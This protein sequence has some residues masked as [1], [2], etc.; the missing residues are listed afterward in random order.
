MSGN[1]LRASVIGLILALFTPAIASA[2]NEATLDTVVVTASRAEESLREVSS[3]VTVISEKQIKNSTANNLGD[4]LKQQGFYVYDNLGGSQDLQIRGIQSEI[5]NPVASET[6]VLILINGRRTGI[7][8]L[9]PVGL[10]NIERIEII[11][12][13]AAV[14]YGSSALGGV[15]NLITKQGKEGEF[16]GAAETGVGSFNLYKNSLGFGGAANNFDFSAGITH[17]KRGDFESN[18]TTGITHDSFDGHTTINLD[19]GYTWFE[20]HRLGLNFNHDKLKDQ[21]TIVVPPLWWAEAESISAYENNNMAISYEGTSEDDQFNWSAVYSFGKDKQDNFLDQGGFTSTT[22]VYQDVNG[23]TGQVGYNG[24]MVSANI[25]LD[26]Y[27]FET[28]TDDYGNDKHDDLGIFLSTKLRLLDESLIFSAG[29]RYDR[30]TFTNREPDP[31][32]TGGNE[33]KFTPSVGVA[34]LP[35]DWLKIRTN[36]SEGFRIPSTRQKYGTGGQWFWLPNLD[37][38]PE[39]SKTFEFGSDVNYQALNASLTYFHTSFDNKIQWNGQFTPN[40]QAINIRKSTISGLEFSVSSDIGQMLDQSFELRP[41]LNLTYY[42]SRKNKDPDEFINVGGTMRDTLPYVPKY[43]LNYGMTF[44]HPGYDLMA[45]ING[46]YLGETLIQSTS[47][48]NQYYTYGTVSVD[49]SLEKGIY[50]FNDKNKLKLRVEVNNLLNNDNM[51]VL[52]RPGPERNFYVGL[53]YEYN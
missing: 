5:G 21:R 47:L 17:L 1:W 28:E 52:M 3:N 16:W 11:R 6:R 35:L 15:V 38:Q 14:Q 32:S 8:N 42:T 9:G 41:Y 46:T 13:P 24:Q 49:L 40:A 20:K 10:S 12:G 50:D 2:Q 33:T 34:Y 44:T 27:S 22:K 7:T 48:G 43:T 19:L 39:K 37:L 30:F 25:G 45:N 18:T 23:F 53:K 51:V 29:G 36:Y 4:L 31:I 26:Y